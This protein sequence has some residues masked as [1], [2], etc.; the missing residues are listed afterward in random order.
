MNRPLH[1][2]WLAIA[3]TCLATAV[4]AD[5][6]Y[7]PDRYRGLTSDLRA[8]QPGDILNVIVLESSSAAASA[9][10][11]TDRSS[12]IGANAQGQIT[13]VGGG[14]ADGDVALRSDFSGQAG[15]A[16]E[17]RLVARVSV[18]V[19]EV[20][21]NGDLWVSGKQTL[22]LNQETQEIIVEGQV[23]PIDIA[24]D[25][26]VLSTRLANSVIHYTGDGILSSTERKPW[27]LRLWDWLF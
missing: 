12:G 22:H 9:S 17:G 20:M 10:A 11:E 1:T 14:S 25:N 6:L 18:T 3:G 27:Y 13:G 5:G 16:R 15:L 7:S 19:E 26:S 23:R 2:L 4:L 21:P 24:R 8:S